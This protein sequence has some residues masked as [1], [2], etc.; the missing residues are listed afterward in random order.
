MSDDPRLA[1]HRAMLSMWMPQALHAAAEL[2]L[3]DA[4]AA[5]PRTSQ[6]IAIAI[7]AHP[8]STDRLCAALATLGALARDGDRWALTALGRCLVSS[9]RADRATA[10]EPSSLRAVARLMGGRAVWDAWGR[11]S[12]CVRTGRPA[13]AVDQ[14]DAVPVFAAFE[15]DPESAE[16]FHRAMAEW[17][18][19]VG[20]GIVRALDLSR[21][22]HVVDVG[23]GWGELLACALEAAPRATGT[24]FDLGPAEPGARSHLSARAVAERAR[25]VAGD[26]FRT[27]P[28]QADVFLLKSVIHDWDDDRSRQILGQCR[29]A[30]RPDDRLY[31]IEPPF[32]S[33]R[34]GSP[35]EWM[36]SF[37][38]LNML[39]NTGG[40][41]RTEPEYRALIESAGLACRAV[42]ATDGPYRAFECA[43]A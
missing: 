41:E 16:I 18:R 15:G 12:D 24:I 38:D 30:L 28:P 14:S 8:P 11:L 1:F 39:V 42:H 9:E 22:D 13:Y 26:V 32:P 2:G 4:L 23:G 33:T 17:T 20:P 31:V 37:S 40:L 3:A 43:R 35:A 34:E 6:D 5:A 27:P 7:G 19:G 36:L 29:D 10:P 25:F 21:A